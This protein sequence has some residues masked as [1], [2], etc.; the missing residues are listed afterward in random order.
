[1]SE[2]H[3]NIT[4]EI[5][6]WI[7]EQ[8]VF[9]VATAPSALDGHVNVSPKGGDS[10]RVLGPLEVV[11]QDFTGSG[12]ETAAHAREN[13]RIVVMFCAFEGPPKIVRIHGHATLIT[14]E[15]P[16]Y[17]EFAELFP[18]N[19]GT[20]AFIHIRV[21]RVSDSCGYSVP[22]YQFQRQRATLDCWASAKTPEG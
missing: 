10:F 22:L 2:S 15:D 3:E 8:R 1:M 12:A 14:G 11:Y 21:D 7:C 17:A 18:P 16:R 13:G 6:T 5:S 9:F 19:P 4:P 20:R